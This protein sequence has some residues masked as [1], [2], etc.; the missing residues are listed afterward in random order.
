[1]R[2]TKFEF[3][4]LVKK[5]FPEAVISSDFEGQIIIYTNLMESEDFIVPFEP[6]K[7]DID[8]D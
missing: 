8:V 1:M 5:S 6:E 4:N 2:V 3:I 7:T